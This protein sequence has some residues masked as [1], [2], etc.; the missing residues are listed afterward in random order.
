MSKKYSSDKDMQLLFE[1]FRENVKNNDVEQEPE[2]V[3]EAVGTLIG[4][5]IAQII[6]TFGAY[7]IFKAIDKAAGTNFSKGT[8]QMQAIDD[9]FKA[10]DF[11]VKD[12]FTSKLGKEPAI[13]RKDAIEKMRQMKKDKG[14][15]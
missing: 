4:M 5:A 6:G 10:K 15:T 2:Q 1:S 3:N 14:Y 12:K 8:H 7:A 11:E 9:A 13:S